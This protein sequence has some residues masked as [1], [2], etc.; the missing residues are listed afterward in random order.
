MATDA[1]LIGWSLTGDAEA[2]VT[3]VRRHEQAVGAYL[4]RRVGRVTAEDLLGEVWLAAYSSRASYDRS[5]PDARPWLFGVAVNLLRRHWRSLPPED[6]V[7]E[8]TELGAGFDPWPLVDA[9]VD[10]AVL[11]R[12]ALAAL[13]E[14]EREVVT[15]MAWEGLTVTGAA[16]A[17]AIPAGTARRYLHQARMALRT[18]PGVLSL[19]HELRP[20]REVEA[21]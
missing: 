21:K 16:R 2:F 9:R 18:A 1:E 17:L 13:R 4:V 20:T 12:R 8:L 7:A 15:L 5:Y 6:N 11:M 10:A 3:V 14:E 19:F